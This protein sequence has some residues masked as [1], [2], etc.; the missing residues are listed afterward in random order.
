MISFHHCCQ[1]GIAVVVLVDLVDPLVLPVLVFV[2]WVLWLKKTESTNP[3]KSLGKSGDDDFTR[4]T[5]DS[6]VLVDVA[7]AFG[8]AIFDDGGS[9]FSFIVRT[10]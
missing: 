4:G 6:L 8:I 10:R 9:G 1:S 2:V 3:L 5:E 7:A